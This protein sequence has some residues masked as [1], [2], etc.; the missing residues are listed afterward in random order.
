M[1]KTVTNVMANVPISYQTEGMTMEEVRTELMK[2]GYGTTK[3]EKRAKE[4]LVSAQLQTDGRKNSAGEMLYF[5]VYWP[6]AYRELDL[7]PNRI[8]AVEYV[9]A[10][11]NILRRVDGRVQQWLLG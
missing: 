6:L 1:A 7:D 10:R 2:A 4:L 3:A 5:Y 11:H 8:G 9:D